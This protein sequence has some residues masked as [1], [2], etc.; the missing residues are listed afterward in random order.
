MADT[1]ADLFYF[2]G[3]VPVRGEV[4]A[5]EETGFVLKLWR[6]IPV[7]TCIRVRRPVPA[8]QETK[9]E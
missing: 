3:D 5:H 7:V 9:Q 4:I 1:L 2:V 8:D 6:L